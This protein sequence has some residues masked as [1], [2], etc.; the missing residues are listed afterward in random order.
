MSQVCDP[1][2]PSPLRV[3]TSFTRTGTYG[4]HL[5]LSAFAHLKRKNVKV[6]QP[7]IVYVIEWSAGN[8]IPESFSSASDNDD[9]ALLSPTQER[10]MR[11]ARREKLRDSKLGAKA[12]PTDTVYVAYVFTSIVLLK[13]HRCDTESFTQLS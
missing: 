12:S 9:Q 8:P 6:I 4:G 1:C 13:A 7:G 11:R 3:Y 5:E 10:E 2:G